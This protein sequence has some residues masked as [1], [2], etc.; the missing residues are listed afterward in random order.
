[1][2]IENVK[3][4]PIKDLNKSRKERIAAIVKEAESTANLF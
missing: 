4:L 1:M 3:S 2:Q